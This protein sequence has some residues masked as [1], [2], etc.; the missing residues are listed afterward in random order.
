[1]GAE[2][3]RPQVTNI[4]ICMGAVGFRPHAFFLKKLFVVCG[5]FVIFVLRGGGD[6]FLDRRH[7]C[8]NK[9][10]KLFPR[11]SPSDGC[12]R[13]NAQFSGAGLSFPPVR[14]RG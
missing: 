6:C 1:M 9:Q 8:T 4:I 12:D 7:A 5:P 10:K 11:N 14:V 3:H 2:A 13:R